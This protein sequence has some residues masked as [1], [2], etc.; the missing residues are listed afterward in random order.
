MG[1]RDCASEDRPVVDAVHQPVFLVGSMRSGTSMLRLMLDNHPELAFFH[2]FPFSVE[3]LDDDEVGWPDMEEYYRYLAT[4]RIFQDS[5]LAVDSGLDYPGLMNSFLR[6][7]RDRDG[8]RL[9]GATVHLQFDR[10]LRIWPDAR[11][12]YMLRDG[13]DVARSC[14]GMGWAGNMYR[15]VNSWILAEDLWKSF[16]ASL[17]PERWIEIRYEELVRDPVPVLTRIC[18][19]VGLEYHP[20][21]LGYGRSSTYEAPDPKL[22]EQWRTKLSPWE[23]RLAEARIGD[24]LAERGYELSGQPRLKVGPLF[25]WC[26]NQHDRWNRLA[27]RRRRLGMS[28][29]ASEMFMRMAAPSLRY[30][31]R[32][33]RRTVLRLHEVERAYLK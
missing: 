31:E 33:Q 13:R 15:A 3:M 1:V 30:L 21:M 8:K 24:T 20:A 23:L 10:L 28:L 16:A 9:V 7:K 26:L 4:N 11:F 14:M 18:Q 29:L 5:G 27:F 22:A 12:V 2:E 19:F 32:Q 17:G 25:H 6:Q